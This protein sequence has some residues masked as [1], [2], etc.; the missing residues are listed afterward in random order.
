MTE[1][2]RRYGGRAAEERTAERRTRLL[3]AGLALM[4]TRGV[5]GTTVRGVAEESGLAARYFYESFP[6]IEALQLAVFEQIA[7]EAAA[8][9]LAAL[10]TAPDDAVARTRA[11]LAEMVE[12]FLEDPR[13]GRIALLESI[14]SPVL[15]PRVLAE[16]RRFAGMLAATASSGDPAESPEGLPVEVRLRAQFLIGGVAHTLGAALHG[17]IEVERERLVDVL[18]E[19]FVSAAAVRP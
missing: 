10:A 12:L 2:A 6:S 15:G 14:T 11:V 19:L 5:A 8:R 16:S 1:S 7:A 4:G 13:K 18:V 17:D 9:S 3:D